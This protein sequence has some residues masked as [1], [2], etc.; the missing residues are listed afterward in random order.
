M[1]FSENDAIFTKLKHEVR[2]LE[3][4][5]Y[6][7]GKKFKQPRLIAYMA[8]K[9]DLY[10]TYSRLQLT[11]VAFTPTVQSVKEEAEKLAGTKFNCCL[12][13]YYRN[14]QDCMGLHSDDEPLFGDRPTIASVSFGCPRDFMLVRNTDTLDKLK[15]S[16]GNGDVLVMK[17]TT[18]DHWKHYVPR[19]A[20]VFEG[21]IN[22]TFRLVKFPEKKK[23]QRTL[24][25]PCE[26][27]PAGGPAGAVN[28]VKGGKSTAN[29]GRGTTLI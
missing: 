12:L 9:L 17:G 16:L 18:Q 10:Y 15:F 2:W 19:R 27:E 14:G 3:K 28:G 1:H 7:W 29:N 5:V 20:Q 11:P 23:K 26:P 21:R 13:N 4:D 22:L 8:D 24:P 25:V 6:S